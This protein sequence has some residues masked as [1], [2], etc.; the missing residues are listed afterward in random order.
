MQVIASKSWSVWIFVRLNL[1]FVF[2]RRYTYA[3]TYM[4]TMSSNNS[5]EWWRDFMF[6]SANRPFDF[7]LCGYMRGLKGRNRNKTIQT[8][9]VL[10]KYSIGAY[11]LNI[12]KIWILMKL[13]VPTYCDH[14]QKLNYIIKKLY[15]M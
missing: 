1:S 3:Y 5:W 14:A 9:P 11:L 10:L 7:A 2:P 13:N 15:N 8:L 12:P 4:V 6:F